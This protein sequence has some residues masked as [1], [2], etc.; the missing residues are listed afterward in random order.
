MKPSYYTLHIVAS[1]TGATASWEFPRLA[2]SLEND[3][4]PLPF[5]TSSH[6]IDED[7]IDIV[8]GSRFHGL[9]TYANLPYV[10]CF[11]DEE[12]QE[13]KYDIAILGA[14]FDTVSVI[15]E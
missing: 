9:K 7:N 10:N 12:A 6:N 11:S 4:H 3:Q 13:Q 5:S 8:T 1:L 15:L 14:P 2:L